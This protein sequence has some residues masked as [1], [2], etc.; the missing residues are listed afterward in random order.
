MSRDMRGYMFRNRWGA[1]LFVCITLAGAASLVGTEEG[2]GAIQQATDEIAQQKAQADQWTTDTQAPS[3]ATAS[4][5]ATT[6]VSTSDE[7]LIDPATGIDPTPIDEFA[8]ANPADSDAEVDE[9]VIVSR[10][11]EQPPPDQ[12]TGSVPAN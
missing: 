8:A 10:G 2:Q 11:P 9:V 7:D 12:T 4:A 1:L 3:A 6:V 5:T